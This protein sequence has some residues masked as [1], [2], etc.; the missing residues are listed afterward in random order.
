MEN[1]AFDS[2]DI[3]QFV[4]ALEKAFDQKNLPF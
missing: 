2:L 4:V 1:L 3:V